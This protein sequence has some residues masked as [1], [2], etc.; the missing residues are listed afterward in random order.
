MLLSYLVATTAL[1]EGLAIGGAA[2][3]MLM[4]NE[5]GQD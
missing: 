1:V 3:L 2:T 4:Q 5:Q